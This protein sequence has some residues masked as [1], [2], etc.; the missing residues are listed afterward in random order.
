MRTVDEIVEQAKRLPIN[1]RRELRERLEELEAEGE[2]GELVAERPYAGWLAAAGSMHSD[3]TDV[4]E[5]KCKHVA[6]AIWE[7]KHE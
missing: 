3:F 7:H 2:E 5:N 4:S 1:E 6:D